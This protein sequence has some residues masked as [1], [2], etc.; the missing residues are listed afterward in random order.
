M[1]K[2]SSISCAIFFI[3]VVLSGCVS[4]GTMPGVSDGRGVQ[5]EYEQR[6]FANDGTL[7]ITMPDGETYAGK[8]VQ[9][10]S[11]TFGDEWLI[12]ESSG[13]DSFIFNSSGTVSSQAEAILIGD[14]KSTMKCKFQFSDPDSGAVGGG[15]GSCQTSTGSPIDFVF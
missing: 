1:L 3:P 15:I 5:F 14:R 8:F 12:G 6:L 13:D 2:Q 10:A 9:K 11:S 4:T 7:R